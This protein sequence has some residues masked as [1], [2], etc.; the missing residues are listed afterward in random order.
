MVTRHVA[1]VTREYSYRD[2]RIL[3]HFIRYILRG[4]WDEKI[5]CVK[6]RNWGDRVKHAR[7][8]YRY[9]KNRYNYSSSLTKTSK[10]RSNSHN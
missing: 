7:D 3:K 8:T 2:R 6:P 4:F 10:N 9:G 1:I 5:N